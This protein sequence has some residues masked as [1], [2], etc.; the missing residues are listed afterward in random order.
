MYIPLTYLV[1]PA[2]RAFWWTKINV[3][4]DLLNTTEEMLKRMKK[5]FKI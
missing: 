1:F 3:P 5:K 4:I 2:Q